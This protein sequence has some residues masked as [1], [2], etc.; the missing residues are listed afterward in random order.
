[1]NDKSVDEAEL[2]SEVADYLEWQKRLG[3]PGLP[4]EM[5]RK[6]LAEERAKR[7]EGTSPAA[8]RGKENAHEG[9]AF[10]KETQAGPQKGGTVFDQV[11][12]GLF[13]VIEPRPT[14]E[15]IS[16]E[17]GDCRRCK[18]W[19]G[20]NSIVFGE[21]DP[22]A[23]IIFIG[24]GPGEDEDRQGRPFVGRAGKLLT[25]WIELGMGIKRENVYIANIIKCRPPKNRDPERDEVEACIGFLKKQIKA[26]RPKVIVLLG[27]VPKQRLL[28]VR[29]GITKI[30]GAWYRYEGIPVMP[31]FHPSYCLRPPQDEKRRIIWGDLKK[32]LTFLGMPVPGKDK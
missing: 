23:D 21:G 8:K 6:R 7:D 12:T 19:E 2:A 27:N 9:D 15:S 14:L 5:L 11:Q 32:L 18:L 16:E 25:R 20:R 29:E 31:I 22:D 3:H 30:H 26:I 1:M 24:E 13:D 28:G 17:I 10:P 4:L